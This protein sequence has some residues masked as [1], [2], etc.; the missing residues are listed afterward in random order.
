MSKI[1][2]A[3]AASLLEGVYDLH[4]HSAPDVLKRKVTDYDMAER[5]IARKMGGFVSKN[6]F[7]CTAQRA[8]MTQEKYPQCHAVGSVCLNAAVGGINPI[9]VE[10]AARAGARLVWFPTCDAQWEREYAEQESGKKA[11][12]ANIVEDLEKSGVHAPG[13]AILDDQGRLKPEAM[14]VL[15]IIRKNDLVLCTGHLSHEETFALV[16]AAHDQGVKRIIITHVTFPS[17]FYTIDEQRE[18]IRL[19]AR[20]EQCYSTYSTQKVAFETMLHQIQTIGAEHYVLGT[21]LGQVVRGYPDDGMFA[22]VSDL[23]EGGI[24]ENDI[25]RMARDNSRELVCP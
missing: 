12:W 17:T 25:R 23:Y 24:S 13:I 15:E 10:M 2:P 1:D 5:M 11:F 16:K 7:F 22:F 3:L 19:G 18:L 14:D 6:H 4:V 20:M 21:D 9:A 8:E